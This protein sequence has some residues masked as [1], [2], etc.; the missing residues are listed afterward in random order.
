M[1]PH[2]PTHTP[3]HT[4]TRR[5]R[6]TDTLFLTVHASLVCERSIAFSDLHA[7]GWCSLAQGICS[8]ALSGSCTSG[9]EDHRPS[10]PSSQYL[11]SASIL[12]PY[13]TPWDRSQQ[14][15]W[16]CIAVRR[17][18][19]ILKRGPPTDSHARTHWVPPLS[20]TLSAKHNH[21]DQHNRSSTNRTV[22]HLHS[23]VSPPT[24]SVLRSSPVPGQGIPSSSAT[25]QSA[26]RLNRT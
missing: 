7:A 5:S 14:Q 22:Y 17:L 1:I 9:E 25:P 18:G 4:C 6:A 2:T 12:K 19:T 21:I 13:T 24:S 16:I 3:T 26:K 8:L 15:T 20:R 23:T 11:S 10:P